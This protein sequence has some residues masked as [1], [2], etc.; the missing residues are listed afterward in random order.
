M[1]EDSL[2]IP[3][4]LD[5]NTLLDLLA[6]MEDGFST[7]SKI[8]TRDSDSKSTGIGADGHFGIQVFLI[9]LK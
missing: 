1:V 8:I 9:F 6:S 7:A 2:G 5:S 3:I 4:Y